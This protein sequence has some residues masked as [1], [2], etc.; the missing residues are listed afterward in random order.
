MASEGASAGLSPTVVQVFDQFVAVLRADDAMQN[1][2]VDRL[3]KLLRK[4]NVPKPE[5]IYA[6]LFESPLDG[7]T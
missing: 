6:A 5:E 4:G 7:A 3:E 2:A 1:D